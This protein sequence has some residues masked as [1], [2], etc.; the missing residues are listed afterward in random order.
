MIGI[1]HLQF[2]HHSGDGAVHDPFFLLILSS[3]AWSL[4]LSISYYTKG[5]ERKVITTLPC[6]KVTLC[7]QLQ[8]AVVL[9]VL[10]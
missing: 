5:G 2:P 6:N 9:L 8:A 10:E 3:E 4:K 1:P 7:L